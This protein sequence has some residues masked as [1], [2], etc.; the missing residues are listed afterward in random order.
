MSA[1]ELLVP[2]D[3]FCVPLSALFFLSFL[4]LAYTLILLLMV[5]L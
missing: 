1:I 2:M 4:F 3:G 5:T